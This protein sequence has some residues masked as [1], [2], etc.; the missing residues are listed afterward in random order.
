MFHNLADSTH[1]NKKFFTIGTVT[2]L[3]EHQ[4]IESLF[5]AIK[6][7]L[8]IIP[9]IQLV[10]VGDGKEKKNLLWLAKKMEIDNLVWLVGK[11][12]HLRKWIDNFDIYITSDDKLTLSEL[13]ITLNAMAAE[14]PTIGNANSGLEDIIYEGK[15]GYLV[16]LNDSEAVADKILLLHQD[17]DLR[18]TLG[19]KAFE[20]VEKYFTSAKMLEQLEKL[21]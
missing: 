2:N 14:K 6:K 4:K 11:Q 16:D 7:C 3:N 18:R 9:N 20:R 21:L 17:K 15:T 13:I 1:A 10:I 12:Q 5:Q 19:K 8:S